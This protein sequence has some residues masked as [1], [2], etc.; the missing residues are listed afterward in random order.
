MDKKLKRIISILGLFVVFCYLAV[1][2]IFVV[3][4]SET[5][6]TIMEILTIISA[7]YIFLLLETILTESNIENQI[8]KHFALISMAGCII[9]TSTTHIVN[10]VVTRQLISQGVNVPIFFQ[11][12]Q[13]PSVEM[14]LDYLAWGLFLGIAFICTA[15]TIKR[16]NEIILKQILFVCGCLCIIGFVGSMFNFVNLWYIAVLGYT[17]GLAVVCI[18]QIKLNK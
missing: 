4:G 12:G 11:I 10:L 8:Q 18:E 13:W 17:L 7:F 9:L 3:T 6:L 14:A 5:F 15:F 16:D 1:V 2:I